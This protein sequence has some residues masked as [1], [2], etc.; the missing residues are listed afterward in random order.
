MTN[1][2]YPDCRLLTEEGRV[3]HFKQLM[4][5][6]IPHIITPEVI[7]Y[8]KDVA[9]FFKAPA[10]IKHHGA[11]AGGLFMHSVAVTNVLLT[12]TD[13]LEL[14]WDRKESPYLVGMFHDL[15]KTD[16]YVL[17]ENGWDYN[18]DKVLTGH[19]E[20]SVILA[21]QLLK[22]S[23]TEQ[24]ILCIRWHMGAFDDKE[25]W[26]AYGKA[27]EYDQ[28]VLYTHTADMHAARVFNI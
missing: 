26:N 22:G 21:Q 27:V 9:G 7:Q 23:L 10:A 20:K 4:A 11:Y 25:N 2:L 24:E 14:H 6:C 16:D 5:P 17:T 15:C 3:E 19:G 12:Y 18:K 13:R 28:N 1:T 8:L